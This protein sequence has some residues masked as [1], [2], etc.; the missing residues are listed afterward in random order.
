MRLLE[1]GLL[2]IA[3]ISMIAISLRMTF[4]EN[5]VFRSSQKNCRDTDTVNSNASVDDFAM[6]SKQSQ[7]QHERVRT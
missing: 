2:V 7:G 3:F 6:R 5:A 1:N 4:Y